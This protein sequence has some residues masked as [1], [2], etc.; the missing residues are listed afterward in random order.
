[1]STVIRRVILVEPSS[2]NLHVFSR[3][4]LPRL[5]VPLL[6]TILRD[7]GYEVRVLVEPVRPIRDEE[8]LDA[9]IVGISVL[10]PTASRAWEMADVVRRRGIPV[11][12]GGPHPTHRPEE[13][14][15]HGDYVIQ[16]EAE[17]SLPDLLAALSLDPAEREQA[18]DRVAGLCR[19]VGDTIRRQ[20]Q[21]P[22]EQNLDRWPDP[23]LSLVEGFFTRGLNGRRIVPIM[24]SRGCPYDCSFCSVTPTF[25]RKMRY[26]SVDRVVAEIA[27]HDPSATNI[28]FYDDNFAASPS[29]AREILAG[30]R[31]LPRGFSWSAQVRA[32]V[33][34]DESLLAEMRA[35]GCETFYIGLES[36][37]PASLKAVD[38]K[39]EISQVA[40]NLDRIHEAG[41]DVHGMF[42][43]GFDT[44]TDDTVARTVEFARKHHLF[45]VQFMLLTPLPGSRLARE[46]N[47]A[48]RIL[49]ED[50]SRYDSH[51]VCYWPVHVTPTE[52]QHQQI[53]G[54]DRFYS[55]AEG[56]RR[57]AH[58]DWT[59]ALVV[60]YARRL[61]KQWRSANEAYLLELE[62]ISRPRTVVGQRQGACSG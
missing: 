56:F 58:W 52:L 11:I 61:N 47:A 25:G 60:A 10:T 3:F 42:I 32:D 26:R 43:F 45:S 4:K 46:M 55:L 44:D 40:R 54:H 8:L 51:H 31:T 17:Q 59:G 57:L 21:A 14:L 15:E 7:L 23:D 38:K 39:Q 1:M 24:T 2:H 48:G 50:W 34:N 30:L 49:T 9:D 13:A 20:P 12:L 53:E 5:G 62:Q 28:F 41:I 29:R 6:G 18:L 33:A 35:T 16:G 36:V 37:D 22:F 27:R 19:R